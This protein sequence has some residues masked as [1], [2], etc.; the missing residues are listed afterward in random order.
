LLQ[1]LKQSAADY[2]KGFDPSV[3]SFP[4]CEQLQ[5]QYCDKIHPEP[6]NCL[7]KDGSVKSVVPDPDVPNGCDANSLEYE[8]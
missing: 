1:F 4:Q 3:H 5:Q 7:F 8:P 6:Y 2:I